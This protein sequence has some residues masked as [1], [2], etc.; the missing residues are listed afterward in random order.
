VCHITANM[1]LLCF[2]FSP[3]G[4]LFSFGVNPLAHIN[5]RFGKKVSKGKYLNV[6]KVGNSIS[7]FFHPCLRSSFIQQWSLL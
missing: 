5:G 7:C 4:K 1:N 6:K 2:G 3:K